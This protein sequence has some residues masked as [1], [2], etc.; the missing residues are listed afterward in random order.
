VTQVNSVRSIPSCRGTDTPYISMESIHATVERLWTRCVG[1]PESAETLTPFR[2]LKSCGSTQFP[3]PLV[4]T[5][6]EYKIC[7]ELF[8]V[9]ID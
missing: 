3:A 7:I 4:S 6:G 9:Q 1:Y 8:L 2:R 5:K